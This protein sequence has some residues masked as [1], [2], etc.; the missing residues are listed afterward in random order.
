MH[1]EIEKQKLLIRWSD[2][3]SIIAEDS[4]KRVETAIKF[5]MGDKTMP[6]STNTD[7]T[8]IEFFIITLP[9]TTKSKPSLINPPIIGIEFEIAYFVALN[10]IPSKLALVIPCTDKNAVK[11]V[12]II[13]DNRIDHSNESGVTTVINTP[14]A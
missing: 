10:D 6:N 5:N 13:P 8:P 11:T 9:A 3:G 7:V 14:I 1:F 2:I 12:T 4:F